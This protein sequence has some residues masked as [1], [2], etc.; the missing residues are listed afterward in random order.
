MQN[1]SFLQQCLGHVS[2]SKNK[3]QMNEIWNLGYVFKLKETVNGQN[4]P[5]SE[6]TLLEKIIVLLDFF[7][8]RCNNFFKT[9]KF[10]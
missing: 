10:M 5:P 2:Q 4:R 8:N 7:K 3:W 9:S 6:D 1:F